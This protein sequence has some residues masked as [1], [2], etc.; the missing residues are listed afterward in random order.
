MAPMR[1]TAPTGSGSPKASLF[2]DQ[3]ALPFLPCAS[4]DKDDS[5]T[6]EPTAATNRRWRTG[7]LRC[8]KLKWQT[9]VYPDRHVGASDQ[10]AILRL[11]RSHTRAVPSLPPASRKLP[12]VEK[13][14]LRMAD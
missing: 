8:N 3:I 5:S 4:A 9:P 2:S 7:S 10:L 6:S 1:A 12:S 11:A 13:R 14:T